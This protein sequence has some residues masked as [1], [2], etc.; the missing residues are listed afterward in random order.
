MPCFVLSTLQILNNLIL[1]QSYYVAVIITFL[2]QRRKQVPQLVRGRASF[3]FCV[4]S[5]VITITTISTAASS[6]GLDG[7]NTKNKAGQ[8]YQVECWMFSVNHL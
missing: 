4:C 5:D 8:I 7:G 2:L 6:N 3:R 1:Q